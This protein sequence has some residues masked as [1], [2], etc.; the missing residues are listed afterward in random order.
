MNSP[1]DSSI[2]LGTILYQLFASL[3]LLL[4]LILFIVLIIYVVRIV[5]RMERRADERLK[6]DQ[7]MSTLQ[8]QQMNAI[9]DINKRLT[10]IEQT[11]KQVD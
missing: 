11:L 7:E 3:T 5:R 10:A 1:M 2:Q 9:Q 6:I 8:Q 4:P